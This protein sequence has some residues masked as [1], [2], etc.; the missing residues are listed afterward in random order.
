VV[1]ME[2]GTPLGAR[3]VC[4]QLHRKFPEVLE[5][6]KDPIASV[7]TVLNRLVEYTEARCSLNEEGRRTWQWIAE[8]GDV[9]ASL[10]AKRGTSELP[11]A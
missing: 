6:H 3:Q 7:T 10:L 9:S 2:A 1:L 5:R 11:I 8:R 4:E